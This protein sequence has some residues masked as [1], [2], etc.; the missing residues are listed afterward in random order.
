MEDDPAGHAVDLTSSAFADS[1][2]GQPSGKARNG[3]KVGVAPVVGVPA[4]TAPGV[5]T[6]ADG[7]SGVA[8]HTV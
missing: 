2:R 5:S 8:G 3:R 6:G 4:G 7:G 1:V